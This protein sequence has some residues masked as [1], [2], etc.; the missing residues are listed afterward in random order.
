M[1]FYRWRKALRDCRVASRLVRRNIALQF[2]PMYRLALIVSL[3]TIA[4]GLAQAD[5]AREALDQIS[6]CASIADS[7][8]RLQCFDRAAPAAK[9]ALVPK[10]ADFGKPVAPPPEVAQ[11]VAVV[12]QLSKT[13]HGRALFV[14]DNGQTWRQLDGDDVQVP[15]PPSGTALKVTIE[16]GL[17]GSYHLMIEG[18]NGLVRVR[19]VD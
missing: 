13:V 16:R 14:L 11:V 12:T 15:E 8:E 2:R 19:R 4:A 5:T 17:F 6:Q 7:A 9:G 3:W 10:A 1:A 18:R